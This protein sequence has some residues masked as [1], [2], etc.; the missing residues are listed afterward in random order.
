MPGLRG[1]VATPQPVT[2]NQRRSA[3]VRL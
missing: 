3:P 1:E 2:R